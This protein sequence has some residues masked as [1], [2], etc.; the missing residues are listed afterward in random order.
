MQ[1]RKT[2]P[3]PPPRSAIPTRL[4]PVTFLPTPTPPPLLALPT[5]PSSS[6]KRMESYPHRAE[7]EEEEEKKKNS[8]ISPLKRPCSR[9]EGN[10][11]LNPRLYRSF[12][13]EQQQQRRRISPLPRRRRP[14]RTFPL[15][16]WRLPR[17]SLLLPRRWRLPRASL[18]P[19]QPHRRFQFPSS[20]R[21][22][23]SPEVKAGWRGKVGELSVIYICDLHV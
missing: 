3:P 21:N 15:L 11:M 16:R 6:R 2:I 20:K 8:R 19:L 23:M 17:A 5:T 7:E 10:R 4:Y 13:R 22:R 12:L 9:C 1:R 14:L 18:P